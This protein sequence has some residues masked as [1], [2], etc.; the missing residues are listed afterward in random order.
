MMPTS[1]G[2]AMRI[3]NKKTRASMVYLALL[4]TCEANRRSAG[5]LSHKWVAVYHA[6]GPATST[7]VYHQ[8]SNESLRLAGIGRCFARLLSAHQRVVVADQPPRQTEQA[9]PKH[10]HIRERE[11]SLDFE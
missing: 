9:Q 2:P 1:G 6:P 5:R 7:H 11:L 10:I 8:R 4:A 3:S